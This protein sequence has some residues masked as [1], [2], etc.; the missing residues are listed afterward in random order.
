MTLLDQV[1][2]VL[3]TE[4]LRVVLCRA[5]SRKKGKRKRLMGFCSVAT[6]TIFIDLVECRRDGVLP[7]IVLIHEVLHYLFSNASEKW[8]LS[9]E[10]GVYEKC[11]AETRRTLKKI[12]ENAPQWNKTVVMEDW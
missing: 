1:M 4:A 10:T 12:I 3:E 5:E 9:R 6:D 8:V 2:W 7:E 11:F